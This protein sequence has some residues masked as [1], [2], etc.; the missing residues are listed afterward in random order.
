VRIK[1]DLLLLNSDDPNDSN[2]PFDTQMF[3]PSKAMP[4]E[5]TAPEK[6][7]GFLM[8]MER[9]GRLA[10]AHLSGVRRSR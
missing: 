2:A 1:L 3:A 8:P 6:V 5:P 10:E 7:P 4:I 9:C